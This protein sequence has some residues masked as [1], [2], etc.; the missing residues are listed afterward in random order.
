MKVPGLILS[1]NCSPGLTKL[2]SAFHIHCIEISGLASS[3]VV[4]NFTLELSRQTSELARRRSAGVSSVSAMDQAE[5]VASG[6]ETPQPLRFA[7][8]QH[9]RGHHRIDPYFS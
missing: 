3:I 6:V 9:I 1:Y 7:S 2:I 8:P 5:S 4:F